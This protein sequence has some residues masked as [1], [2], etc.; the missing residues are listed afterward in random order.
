MGTRLVAAIGFLLAA[1]GV[2]SW[3][4]IS[5][6]HANTHATAPHASA[7]PTPTPIAL[8]SLIPSSWQLAF[9]PSFTGSRLDPKVWDTCYPW[10]D[11]AFG[12]SNFGHKEYEWY[13]PSQDRVSNGL[14]ELVAQRQPTPGLTKA[15]KPTIY[16]CRS[17][18]VTTYHSFR[19]EYGAVQVVAR[20]PSVGGMWPALWLLPANKS[21]PPEIDIVEHWVRPQYRTGVFLHTKRGRPYNFVQTANLA[22]GWH[23]FT[24]VWTFHQLEWLIDGKIAMVVH[25]HIPHQ[26]MYFLANLANSRPPSKGGCGGTFFVRSVQIWLPPGAKR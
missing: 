19:F 23:T 8:S 16:A 5:A 7:S 1:I 6:G 9:N 12:C 17:G 26:P 18:M 25:Q 2:T 20:M 24:L 14:L 22:V 10:A 15:G 21:F 11:T 3:G 13:L 4:L